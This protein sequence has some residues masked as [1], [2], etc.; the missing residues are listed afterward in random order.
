MHPPVAVG[1][2]NAI[3]APS[4][5]EVAHAAAVVQAV[6][7]ATAA[8]SGAATHEGKMIDAASLRMARTIWIAW[9]RA[10]DARRRPAGRW[11]WGGT[12][13]DRRP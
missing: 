4:A 9:S 7:D 12:R 8:G 6:T 2:A 1:V 3:F 11:G 10:R 13:C 5:E